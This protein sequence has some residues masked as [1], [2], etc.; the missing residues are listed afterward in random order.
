VRLSLPP[1]LEIYSSAVQCGD[2]SLA[3]AFE[4][5]ANV[6]GSMDR[7]SV[8]GYHTNIFDLCLR[9][10]DLRFQH[11]VSVQNI[12]VVEESVISAMIALTMKLTE[13]MFKPLFIRSIEWADSDLEESGSTKSSNI[14]RAISFYSLVNKLLE[15]HR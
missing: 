10:L 4:M 9:A 7:S 1:L 2:S 11:P 6:V 5:L 3:I 15:N 8:Y 14:D 13:T 12:D